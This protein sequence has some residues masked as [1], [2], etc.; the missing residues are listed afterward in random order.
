MIHGNSSCKEVFRNQYEGAIGREFRCVAMDLPGH[1]GSSDASDPERTYWMPGYADCVAEVMRVLGYKRHAVLGWSLGGHV[2]IE[3]VARGDTVSRLMISGSPPFARTQ[4]SVD[5]GFRQN[6]HMHL[7]AQRDLSLEEVSAYARATC[8]SNAPYEPFL[9]AAVART[10]GRARE[11]MFSRIVAPGTTDNREVVSSSPVTL[12]V[13]NGEDDPF[14]DNDFVDAVPYANLWN[15][16]THQLK[17][18]GHAPFWEA[19]EKFDPLL[20]RFLAEDVRS[21]PMNCQVW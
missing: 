21:T 15:G 11:L 12:A 16:R 18:I 7:A 4:A 9:E 17:G 5:K 2:G 13:V 20:C 3:M 14:V 1:G 10:D 6:D 19:P 8:G